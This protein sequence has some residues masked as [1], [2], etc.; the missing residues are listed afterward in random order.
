MFHQPLIY[1]RM[2]QAIL[3]LLAVYCAMVSYYTVSAKE[4]LNWYWRIIF[5]VIP[6]LNFTVICP[7]TLAMLVRILVWHSWQFE[8]NIEKRAGQKKFSFDCLQK[9]YSDEHITCASLEYSKFDRC[10]KNFCFFNTWLY[11]LFIIFFILSLWTKFTIFSSY[12]HMI[13]LT[14]SVT[15]NSIIIVYRHVNPNG[16]DRKSHSKAKKTCWKALDWRSSD[17]TRSRISLK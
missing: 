12:H 5:V 3:F 2:F 14:Y 9:I 8:L 1:V 6:L 16:S 10:Q 4:E 15:S 17:P 13:T 7:V 11:F